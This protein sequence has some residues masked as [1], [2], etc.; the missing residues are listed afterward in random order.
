[1]LIGRGGQLAH[2]P[3]CR[4]LWISGNNDYG[5]LGNDSTTSSR[6]PIANEKLAF[7]AGGWH[8]MVIKMITR[9]G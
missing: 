4:A 6:T 2:G 8:S 1:M 5:Q 3:Q 9:L 7:A